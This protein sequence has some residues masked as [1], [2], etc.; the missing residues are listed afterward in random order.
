MEDQTSEYNGKCAAT[1]GNVSKTKEFLIILNGILNGSEGKVD[2]LSLVHQSVFQSVL[3]QN[4]ELII[5]SDG[6]PIGL[7]ICVFEL[8]MTTL[9]PE[10]PPAIS[11]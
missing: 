1:F 5:A 4:A 8:L 9:A 3:G 11:I 2:G 7:Q 6:C 10:K